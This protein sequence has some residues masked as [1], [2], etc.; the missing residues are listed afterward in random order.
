MAVMVVKSSEVSLE[1]QIISSQRALQSV[2]HTPSCICNG[3]GVT[4][5]STSTIHYLWKSC[6]LSVKHIISASVYIQIITECS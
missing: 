1:L 5:D 4:T 3:S 2:Q 6:Y